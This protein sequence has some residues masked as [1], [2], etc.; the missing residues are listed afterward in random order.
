MATLQKIQEHQNINITFNTDDICIMEAP[1]EILLY[2]LE[3]FRNKSRMYHVVTQKYGS[4]IPVEFLYD[5]CIYFEL[6]HVADSPYTLTMKAINPYGDSK[7]FLTK[8]EFDNLRNFVDKWK[9][10]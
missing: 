9:D 3:E 1:A 7:W 10:K 4:P 5:K 8:D 2:W 6:Y